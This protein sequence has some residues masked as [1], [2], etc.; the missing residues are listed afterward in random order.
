MM[1]VLH[2][3]DQLGM[4]DNEQNIEKL[5]KYLNHSKQVLDKVSQLQ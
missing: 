1:E 2:L 4:R 3:F 5:D